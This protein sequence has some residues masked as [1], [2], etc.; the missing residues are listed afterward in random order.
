MFIWDNMQN[1][2][3]EAGIGVWA[4]LRSE[5]LNHHQCHLKLL[6]ENKIY[7]EQ[8]NKKLLKSAVPPRQGTEKCHGLH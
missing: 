1:Q 4:E 6:Q 5:C 7:S 3:C 8:A 2:G